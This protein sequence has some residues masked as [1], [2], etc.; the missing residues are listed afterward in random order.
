M[1]TYVNKEAY[2][3][4]KKLGSSQRDNIQKRKERYKIQR[5]KGLESKGVDG[6]FWRLIEKPG[7][8]PFY[9]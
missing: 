5:Q 1:C 3:Y 9:R 6:K 8:K 2:I 7:V 4:F